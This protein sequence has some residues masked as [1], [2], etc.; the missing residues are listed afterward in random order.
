MTSDNSSGNA[1][2]AW[3]RPFIFTIVV[4][5]ALASLS[6]VLLS[7]WLLDRVVSTGGLTFVLLQG[8]R[9]D[10]V[11]L[12]MLLVIPMALT[13][14]VSAVRPFHGLWFRFLR[15][16]LAA[17]I[18][19]WVFLEVATPP[20]IMEYDVRPN[21]LFV[22]YLKYPQEVFSMLFAGYRV[23]LLA[24]LIVVPAI[25][26]PAYSRLKKLTAT[27]PRSVAWSAIPLAFLALLACTAAAR[28]TLDH[29]PVNPSTV[30]FSPD[31]LVNS[32][33]L[34][35][36]YSVAYAV[37]E[38]SHEDQGFPYGDIDAATSL[39]EQ[40]EAM[41]LPPDKFPDDQIPT[42][43]YQSATLSPANPL[44]LV[45]IVEESLGAEFVGGLGGL[46]LTPNL[47][48][49]ADEGIWFERLYATGTRSARGLEA[50]VT[51]FPPTSSQSVLKLGN[52]QQDFFTLGSFLRQ[53]GYD[54]SFIYGGE[55]Q[56]DNMKRFFANNGFTT[57]VDKH[58]FVDAA[59]YGSWGASDEDTFNNAHEKFL[60]Q[61]PEKP[62]FSVLFTTSN[63]SPWEY[64]DDRIE[65]YD[66]EKATVN[67]AVKY[68]DYAL[69]QY[70]DKA[71]AS[72]YWQNTV[73]LVVSDHNSRVYGAEF[74]PVERFH[75]PGLIVGGS[76]APKRIG[77]LA[78]QI[79][80]L[81]TVL[82]LI[83]VSGSHPAPGID[84]TRPDLEQL[85]ERTI[86][87]YGDT[88]AYRESDQIVILRKGD[89]AKVY[90]YR[91][92]AFTLAAS[93]DLELIRKAEALAAWPVRAYREH[94]YRLRADDQSSDTAGGSP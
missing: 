81:P 60:S 11:S 73:F 18:G 51:G 87:Q 75:I 16:Y 31:T 13:P 40:R 12:G 59:F 14:L 45:I 4:C 7:A 57:V 19:L 58:D 9:F 61:D 94:Q 72:P 10:L 85:P 21:L 46:P 53:H 15:L 47:D 74:V 8:L 37:Y 70:L 17:V 89:A 56:F 80:L 41:G 28:S 29:R 48:R 50:I 63:H 23:E 83:G 86:M 71:R 35:S 90:D 54:T 6:R 76:V 64:P 32:L 78:S 88:Q 52:A 69:G 67:N 26:W 30:A 34:N 38:L 65:P 66:A 84:L 5:L 62:F 77:R 68:A 33:P 82:S 39:A 93:Q 1:H 49:W 2:L 42:L 3:L 25:I 44:N 20:F 43:H 27:A 91:D 55:A 36:L 24:A 92:G 22:E 79:D